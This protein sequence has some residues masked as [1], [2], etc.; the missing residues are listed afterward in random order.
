[1]A[2]NKFSEENYDNIFLSIDN[3]ALKTQNEK[4]KIAEKL[5]KQ[6]RH[7]STSKILKLVKIFRIED[8]VVK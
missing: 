4:R 1:M 7:S 5:H 2:L 3:I 6:L 8:N